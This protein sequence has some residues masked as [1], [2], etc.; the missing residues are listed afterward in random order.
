M[1]IKHDLAYVVTETWGGDDP[2]YGEAKTQV[3]GVF[4]NIKD[5][6]KCLGEVLPEYFCSYVDTRWFMRPEDIEWLKSFI[7]FSDYSF[8][9][10]DNAF[11]H[12]YKSDKSDPVLTP[13]QRLKLFEKYNHFDTGTVGYGYCI[14]ES[15][16]V[17]VQIVR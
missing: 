11:V 5:A 3:H 12:D 14:T 7:D 15:I 6:N 13:E 1:K 4:S 17:P 8:T 10:V 9:I 16:L 2:M